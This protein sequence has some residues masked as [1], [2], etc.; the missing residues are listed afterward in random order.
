MWLISRVIHGYVIDMDV[1]LS[2]SCASKV[3]QK[4]GVGKIGWYQVTTKW[5][6]VEWGMATGSYTC[7]FSSL[8]SHC[9]LFENKVPVD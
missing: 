1:I 6:H 7:S 9:N 8:W 3:I 5:N 2:L 4:T